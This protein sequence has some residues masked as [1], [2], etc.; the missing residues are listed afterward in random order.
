MEVISSSSRSRGSSV[1]EL[2]QRSWGG[3]EEVSPTN[4]GNIAK[5]QRRTQPGKALLGLPSPRDSPGTKL[6]HPAR[7]QQNQRK[8]VAK[9]PL[10]KILKMPKMPVGPLLSF[11]SAVTCK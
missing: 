10:P 4:L 9:R 3:G 1:S 5:L 7:P 6:S 2:T 11:R 8:A